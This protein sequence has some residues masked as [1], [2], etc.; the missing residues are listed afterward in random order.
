MKIFSIFAK[1]LFILC[2]PFFLFTASIGIAVNSHWLYS[3]GF[4]KYNIPQVTGITVPELNKAATGLIQ[5]FNSGDEYINLQ[6][7]KDG[8]PFTLFNDKEVRHL[9]D[10]KGLIRFDYWILIGTF[11][12]LL[13]YAGFH[14]KRTANKKNLAQVL[15]GGGILTLVL[16]AALGIG[17]LFGFDQLFWDFHLISFS[18]DF[19]LL[20]PN[21]DYMIMM[22]PG[23]FW[24][25]TFGFV[26]ILTL[27]LAVMVGAM[28]GVYLRIISKIRN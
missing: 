25:D 21:T 19:W 5:Y 10:V 7:I 14:V 11:A 2:I 16:G 23:E 1:I 9:K 6:V 20:D 12:Y 4:E 13:I 27:G 3:A 26:A 24:Y 22:F 17:I 28:G 8:Q 18:N 15:F